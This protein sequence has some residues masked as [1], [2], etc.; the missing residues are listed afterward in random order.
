MSVR[1]LSRSGGIYALTGQVAKQVGGVVWPPFL[2]AFAVMCSGITSASIIS[3]AFAATLSNAFN[4]GLSGT[5]GLI[6]IGLGFM[7]LV[8]RET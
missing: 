5:F 8:Q 2:V 3:R 1:L 4:L 6:A 7:A